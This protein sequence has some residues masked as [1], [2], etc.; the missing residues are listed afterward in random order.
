[1]SKKYRFKKRR[2]EQIGIGNNHVSHAHIKHENEIVYDYNMKKDFI[3][4]FLLIAFCT[5]IVIGLYYYDKANNILPSI[6][7]NILSAI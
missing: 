7:E 4:L 1:M 5:S 2:S 3:S 6:S